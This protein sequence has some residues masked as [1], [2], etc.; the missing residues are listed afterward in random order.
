MTKS[1]ILL[2]LLV[3]ALLNVGEIISPGGG[4]SGYPASL[5]AALAD[6]NSLRASAQIL[7]SPGSGI[8]G[9]VRFVEA[10]TDKYTPVSEVWV[11][12]EVKGLSSGLHGFHIHEIGTCDPPGFVTAGGHFD[13]GPAGN[14]LPVD[15]NHP[16]HMG[17][18]PN[19]VANDGGV[20]QL[21]YNT[22]RITIRPGPLSVFDAN[23][24]AIIVHLN[25]DLGTTGVTGAS[26]GPRIACGVIET[27]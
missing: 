25:P 24:S 23:G 14:S 17:D 13:P 27:E 19:L 1:R 20:G 8:T 15:A 2:A 26:G 22:S 6:P 11:V 4:D 9:E 12:A 16:F 3:G 18:L 7:G 5:Q 10:P 21:E